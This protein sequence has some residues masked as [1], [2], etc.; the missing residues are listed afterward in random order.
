MYKYLHNESGNVITALLPAIYFTYQLACGLFNFGENHQRLQTWQSNIFMFLTGYSCSFDMWTS[1]IYHLYSPM[2]KHKC[3]KLLAL[4]MAGICAVILSNFIV[5]AFYLFADWSQ[6][7]LIIMSVF[8]PLILSNFLVIFHPACVKESMFCCKVMVI[9]TTLFSLLVLVIIGRLFLSTDF[10]V[11]VIYPRL[12]TAFAALM[13]GFTFFVSA[14]PERAT[15]N[16]YVELLFNSHVFWHILVFVCEYNLY[17]TCYD[18]NVQHEEQLL[19]QTG[20]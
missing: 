7:R 14:F 2:G 15:N 16:R 4:D 6:E 11:E 5:I 9:F 12:F 10:H 1:F 13:L 17:W 3:E 8:T 20:S 18:L 19:V